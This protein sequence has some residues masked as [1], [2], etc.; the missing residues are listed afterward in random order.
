MVP[1]KFYALF[2]GGT[3]FLNGTPFE[4]API[5]ERIIKKTRE[6]NNSLGMGFDKVRISVAGTSAPKKSI[7]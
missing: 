1:W 7:F 6:T 3:F 4:I 2:F 5:F